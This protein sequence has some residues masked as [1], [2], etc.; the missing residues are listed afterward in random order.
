MSWKSL[1]DLDLDGKTVLTR[2]D[3]NVPV[4][5]GAVADAARWAAMRLDGTRG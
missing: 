1:D 5:N 3:I 4:E 2:V